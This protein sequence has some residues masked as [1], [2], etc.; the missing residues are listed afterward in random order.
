MGNFFVKIYDNR[1][2]VNGRLFLAF[3]EA[4][5]FSELVSQ[6]EMLKD[7]FKE[8]NKTISNPT[9]AKGSTTLNPG[10][11][12]SPTYKAELYIPSS[13]GSAEM[14]FHL[15]IRHQKEKKSRRLIS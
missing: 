9:E 5:Q 14:P 11:F 7:N 10:P 3:E 8:E 13:R 4:V 1:L 15:H 6:L 12:V 2:N